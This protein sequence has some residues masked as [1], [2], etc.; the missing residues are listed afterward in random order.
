VAP[1]KYS[2]FGLAYDRQSEQKYFIGQR[3]IDH[4]ANM[5]LAVS[6]PILRRLMLDRSPLLNESETML[7]GPTWL[8]AASKRPIEQFG[9]AFRTNPR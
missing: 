1:F 5:T 3:K 4:R 8:I 2:A 9:P 7:Y 6:L